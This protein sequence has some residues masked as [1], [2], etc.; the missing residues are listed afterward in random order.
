M[1]KRPFQSRNRS[2]AVTACEV[3]RTTGQEIKRETSR[4]H[5]TEVA[6]ISA[7]DKN[8]RGVKAPAT[9]TGRSGVTQ[10]SL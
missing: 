5:V 4:L 7:S 9:P 2:C 10:N 1:K 6:A 8:R 3:S